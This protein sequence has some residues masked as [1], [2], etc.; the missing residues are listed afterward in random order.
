[1]ADGS[2]AGSEEGPGER[3]EETPPRAPLL[4]MEAVEV[5]RGGRTVLTDVSFAIARGEIVTVVGPNGGGKTSL[6]RTVVGDLR[7]VRGRVTTAPS[8][9]I[10]YMPQRLGID[11]TFPLSVA[12]FVSL[13]EGADRATAR[14]ALEQAGATA[15][16]SRQLAALSGG[17]LQRALLARALAR[18]PDLLVLDEPTQG[19]DHAG[20]AA[21][22][23]LIADIRRRDGASVLLVSH[24]LHVVMS[25]TDRVIC[26][27]GHICCQGAPDAIHADPEYRRLFGADAADALAL[28]RHRHDHTH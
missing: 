14:A 11:R 1:M 20:A 5:A 18:R 27:N 26:V 10:G 2:E 21:F 22:Y 28:Y 7:P 4:T 3:P 19:L 15:L 8:L 13:A 6:I 24:D 9:R 23:R 12:R 25:A 16:A 17:E